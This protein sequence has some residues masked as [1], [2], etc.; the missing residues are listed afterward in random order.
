MNCTHHYASPLGGITM[1]SDGRALTGLWFDGQKHFAETL[2]AGHVERSLPVFDGADRW[3]DL[4]FSGR[5][6]GFTPVL[7]PE[8]SPFRKAVWKIL[9]TVPFGETVTYRQIAERIAKETGTGRMSAQAVGTAV[10]HNPISLIIPCHRVVPSGGGPG[11]YA[12]GTDRKI[13]LLRLEQAVKGTIPAMYETLEGEHIRLRKAKETDW[14]TMLENVW[15]DEAV[16]RWMLF[17]PT[18]T[19]EEAVE[20]CRRSINY[21]K[22]NYAWFVALKD[23][24]EAVGLCAVR[25]YEPGRWEEC[26]ICIGTKCQGKGY[27]KEIVSLLLDLVFV[28]LSASDCRYGYFRDN[29]RSKK[30]AESFGFRYDRSYDL[31]RPWDGEVK[32]IDSCLLTREEYLERMQK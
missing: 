26:G 30:V 7:A 6:P 31:T 18:L 28:K 9:L 1:A 4:Y 20:R 17:Q 2:P 24:D 10:S 14:H 29:E 3:L 13:R 8:G 27:G 25:E 19:E 21:Q 32:H 5:D 23:T 15:G 11:G 22:E 16:Y 12:G